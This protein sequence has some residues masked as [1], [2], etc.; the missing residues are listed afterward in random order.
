MVT[1]DLGKEDCERPQINHI[2]TRTRTNSEEVVDKERTVHRRYNRH[3]WLDLHRQS[4]E[5]R[6]T[7]P[8]AMD[9]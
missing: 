6:Q 5:E 7:Q 9:Y 2:L 3:D 4:N 1:L 8:T